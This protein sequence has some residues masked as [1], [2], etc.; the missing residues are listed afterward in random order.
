MHRHHRISPFPDDDG[1]RAEDDDGELART[2]RTI[3]DR[4]RVAASLSR[5]SRDL[6]DDGTAKGTRA[7]ARDARDAR[8]A[9]GVVE[10]STRARGGERG[11]EETTMLE[12][13]RAVFEALSAMR[14][15]QQRMNGKLSWIS[16][17]LPKISTT[18]WRTT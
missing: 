6:V 13:Q 3:R 9:G 1:M 8:A 2:R 18:P 7:V 16:R 4:A 10:A 11:E 15:T 17:S 12:I 14:E 5:G